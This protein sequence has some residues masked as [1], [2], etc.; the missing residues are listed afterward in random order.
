VD[1]GQTAG[2][3]VTYEINDEGKLVNQETGE[4]YTPGPDLAPHEE[5]IPQWL[6]D[7]HYA[8]PPQEVEP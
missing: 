7:Q 2:S 1:G 8:P 6:R 3:V 4:E 5:T